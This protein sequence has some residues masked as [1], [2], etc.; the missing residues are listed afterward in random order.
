MTKQD[1]AKR[2]QYF[3]HLG[4]EVPREQHDRIKQIAKNNEMTISQL[5]RRA[6]N[7]YL[8]KQ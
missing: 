7:E 5:V 4:V 1:G 8:E 3:T 6:L 2:A